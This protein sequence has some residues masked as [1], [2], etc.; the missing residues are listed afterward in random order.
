MCRSTRSLE[1]ETY[2]LGSH[3]I[4]KTDH[5]PLKSLL[6]QTIQTPDQQKWV[7]KLLGFEFDVIYQPGRDNGPADALSRLPIADNASLNSFSTPT[8]GIL[9]AL[10]SYLATNTKAQELLTKISADPG[11]YPN[12]NIRDGLIL[13]KNRLLVPDCSGLQTLIIHEYHYTPIGGHAGNKRTL[14]RLSANF[15]WP[16]LRKDVTKFISEC[17]TCQRSKYSTTHP[18]GLLQPLPIPA[19]VSESISMDFITHLPLSK[20]KTTIWVVVDRLT[21]YAHFIG[22][23]TKFSAVTLADIFTKEIYRLHGLPHS[24]I[25]DRDTHFLSQFWQELFR[26]QGSVLS[27]STAYHPQT[28]GQ[29][30]VLN[31]CLED[32]LRCFVS[33]TAKDWITHL[34]WAEWSYNT[35]LHSAINTTPFEAVYGRPP[36]TVVDYVQGSSPVEEVDRTLSNR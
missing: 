26:L 28:D 20:R 27:A 8:L 15:Y 14:A 36:P 13:F 30:E 2:L 1:V 17:D 12:Y 18:Q 34:P 32:Y 24:I 5:Q 29:T 31:R 7:S 22:L 21:K 11:S 33:E 35:S 10:R 4:I 19:N 16:N 23:P 6:T 9:K 3:F 25:S